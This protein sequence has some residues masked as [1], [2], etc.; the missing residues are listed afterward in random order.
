MKTTLLGLH[1]A[2]RLAA[3]LGAF[4]FLAAASPRLLADG[5]SIHVD[6]GGPPPPP[7][8]E[9]RPPPPRPDFLWVDGYWGGS[10]G[11]YEWVGGHWERPGPGH[12]VWMAPRW[13]HR[14]GRYVF[15]KGYWR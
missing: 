14:D 2:V 1:R 12:R 5:L 10:P 9:R 8:Y 11:H 13:D 6:L 7:R 3:A 15:V 4:G